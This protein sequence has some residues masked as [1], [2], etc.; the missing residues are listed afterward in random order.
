MHVTMVIYRGVYTLKSNREINKGDLLIMTE[1]MRR[2]GK[3]VLVVGIALILFI[4]RFFG[5]STVVYAAGE[6]VKV[7]NVNERTL[8]VAAGQSVL[9]APN[10]E[11][12]G[13]EF[14]ISSAKVVIE[15]L[16]SDSTTSY[17]NVAGL[18]VSYD[19]SKAVYTISGTAD[20]A[21][22]QTLFRSFRINCGTTL[23]NDVKFNFIVSENTTTPMYYSG[24]GHYYE[25]IASPAISWTTAA[26]AA[27]SRTYNGM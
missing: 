15:S 10:I 27:S 6:S 17:S 8:T 2:F 26:A 25:Y 1:K 21:D 4:V 16:P 19:S 3:T 9:I 22:Y 14:Q 7:P 11:L 23:Q 5:L 12:N 20:A 18:S 24:T 13:F